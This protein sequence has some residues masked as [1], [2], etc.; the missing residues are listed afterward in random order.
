MKNMKL[1][2]EQE[3]KRELSRIRNARYR[4]KHPERIKKNQKRYA[5]STKGK[6]TTSE[7]KDKNKEKH[8]QWFK[9]HYAKLRGIILTHYGLF[10]A[11]CGESDTRFLCIDHINHGRG[12]PAP[13]KEQGGGS[14]F[15]KWLIKHEFPEGYQTLCHNCNWGKFAHGVCPHKLPPS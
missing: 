1:T 3:K 14:N 7:Y 13:R 9:Q 4:E 5:H 8:A 11:C 2:P 10:C 15:Y 12:N 6:E